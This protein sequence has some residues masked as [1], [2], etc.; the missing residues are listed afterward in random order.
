MEREEEPGSF[1]AVPGSPPPAR[2]SRC[3]PGVVYSRAPSRPGWHLLENGGG[4]V[5]QAGHLQSHPDARETATAAPWV[6]QSRRTG[7]VPAVLRPI[8]PSF[9]S[10]ASGVTGSSR[11]ADFPMVPFQQ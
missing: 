8:A 10:R 9:S 3:F 4:L 5:R 1:G 6:L 7:A 2:F 11:L